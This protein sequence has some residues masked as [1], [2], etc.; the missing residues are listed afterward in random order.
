[1]LSKTLPDSIPPRTLT[2]DQVAALWNVHP[3]T[4]QKLYRAG[5]APG[6]L[7]LP[8]FK[9]LIFDRLEQ[10]AAIGARGSRSAA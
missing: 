9:R 5:L 8:G 10:E 2:I 4:F 3:R 7:V 6:P 1:M